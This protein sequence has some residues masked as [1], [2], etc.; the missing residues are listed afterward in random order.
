MQWHTRQMDIKGSLI[1]RKRGRQKA[2][3]RE[4]FFKYASAI[5]RESSEKE[6]K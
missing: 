3:D 1:R 4:N 6:D 2:G 5:V